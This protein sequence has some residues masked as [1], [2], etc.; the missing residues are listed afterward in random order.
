MNA[1][2]T[3]FMTQ[4][5]HQHHQYQGLRPH[6]NQKKKKKK[7]PKE[8]FPNDNKNWMLLNS[9]SNHVQLIIDGYIRNNTKILYIP[10]VIKK[11]IIFFYG[12]TGNFIFQHYRK[13]MAGMTYHCQLFSINNKIALFFR[14]NDLYRDNLF[15]TLFSCRKEPQLIS[16]GICNNHFF[17][18]IY[19]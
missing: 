2:I 6:K 14:Y 16:H 9:I 19:K 11:I 1:L 18:K 3:I 15:R 12:S 4:I 13:H 5:Y 17:F 10:N 8:I 7:K